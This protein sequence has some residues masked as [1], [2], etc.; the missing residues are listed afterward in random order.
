MLGLF[1]NALG[2]IDEFLR[3][4]YYLV[5]KSFRKLT[6]FLDRQQILRQVG[7]V[8]RLNNA[9]LRRYD[10]WLPDVPG[11]LGWGESAGLNLFIANLELRSERLLRL[12]LLLFDLR[13]DELLCEDFWCFLLVLQV[14]GLRHD[15]LCLAVR[16]SYRLDVLHDGALRVPLGGL[17]LPCV[18]QEAVWVR[19]LLLLKHLGLV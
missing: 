2:L 13:L 17:D 1:L 16:F 15:E 11:R 3:A 18:E 14:N 19:H 4:A 6:F 9:L 8:A 7:L 5:P 12:I 10:G